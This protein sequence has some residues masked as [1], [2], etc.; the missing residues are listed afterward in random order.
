MKKSL[1]TIAPLLFAVGLTACANMADSMG[2]M[3]GLGAVSSTT[4]SFDGSTTITVSPNHVYETAEK[5]VA[6]DIR[7]GAHWS[8][9]SPDYVAIDL[10]FQS[11]VG[12]GQAY[13]SLKKLE[14]NIDG[15]MYSYDAVGNTKLKSS[16]YNTV[17][18]MIYTDSKNSVIVPL[19]DL[20]KMIGSANCKMRVTTSEGFE[21]I[22]FS[23]DR[24][25]NG[26][27]TARFSI[28]E[29]LIEIDRQLAS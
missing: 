13:L 16:S 4:A 19:D 28:K 7:L 10:L 11:A 6:N 9:K 25:S 18:K 27:S 17:S 1:K 23:M 26:Q 29:L 8:T 20:R 15:E 3:A 21:D 22:F 24:H 2:K 12:S 14:V 5:W